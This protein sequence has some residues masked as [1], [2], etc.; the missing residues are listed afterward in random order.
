MT[1]L[2]QNRMQK[3]T[4]NNKVLLLD[5]NHPILEEKLLDAGFSCDYF[6]DLTKD[7]L[8]EIIGDY[9]GIIVRL[10]LIHI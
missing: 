7:R 5:T 3:E 10:S 1:A 8:Q 6:P 4:R 2:S 9:S